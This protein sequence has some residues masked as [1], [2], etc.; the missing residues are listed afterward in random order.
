MD[1]DVQ[2]IELVM[3]LRA[4]GIRNTRVLD[5]IEKVPRE[6]FLP[7][8]VRLQAYADQ[9]LPIE[10]GQT[11]SQPFIVAYMTEKLEV[12]DL[13]KVLEVGTGSGYQTAVLSYLCRR[14]YTIERY[15]T[16]AKAAEQRLSQLNRRNITAM[17]GD[18]TKGWPARTTFERIIV[19]A[20]APAG[21]VPPA[22]LSQLAEGGRM[23]IPIELS[24]GRQ[25]LHLI[26]RAAEGYERKS[27]LPVRFVPLLEGTA[28]GA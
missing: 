22:L 19:T 9:A 8:S 12:T 20:C 23:L 5:A 17:I 28:K 25:E 2:K 16:L 15:R 13:T 7:E 18:G 21:R 4:Q 10:C 3:K 11:I 26:T 1:T 27:L 24:G 6:L 14:V